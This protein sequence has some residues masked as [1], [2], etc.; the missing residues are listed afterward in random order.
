[1]F[2]FDIL[3]GTIYSA[4]LAA[5]VAG[6][7]NDPGLGDGYVSLSVNN[8][9]I[10]MNT[11]R[12]DRVVAIGTVAL[13]PLIYEM[14]RKDTSLDTFARCYSACDQIL[15]KAGLQDRVRW[16]GGHIKTDRKTDRVIAT[17]RID[18]DSPAF[19]KK[20]IAEIVHRAKEV[21]ISLVGDR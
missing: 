14:G 4:V 6:L 19:R 17:S 8:S 2:G 16:H 18:G 20:Q 7:H 1:M 10:V 3:A 9:H 13:Q 12:I 15:R 5:F 11:K 21:G